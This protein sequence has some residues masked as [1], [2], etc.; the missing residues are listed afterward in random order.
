MSDPA[1]GLP[2]GPP[3]APKKPDEVLPDAL[4]GKSSEEIFKILQAE[5]VREMAEQTQGYT[6]RLEQLATRPP[7]QPQQPAPQQTSFPFSPPPAEEPG[8]D[9]SNPEEYLSRQVDK[10]MA[11]VIQGM[12]AAGRESGRAIIKGSLPAGHWDRFGKEI[13]QFVD[14][15]NPQMQANPKIYEIAYNFVKGQ[16]ADEI[17]K[18][19]VNVEAKK[20]AVELLKELGIDSESI[21]AH[22]I[23]DGKPQEP[24]RQSLF[25]GRT[26]VSVSTPRSGS[27]AN[28]AASKGKLSNAEK[29]MCAKFEMTEDEYLLYKQDNSDLITQLGERS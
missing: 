19:Q 10:R 27:A 25:Q 22:T 9:L 20:V 4:K 14:A 28:S 8:F 24:A 29:A 2:L 7:E 6:Q 3:A 23:A 18:E 21:S 5:H 12:V 11:P 26:G 15:T 1:T 13:E 16:H 17:I